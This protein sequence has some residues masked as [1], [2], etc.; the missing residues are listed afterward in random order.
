MNLHVDQ[1]ISHPVDL[2]FTTLR[3]RVTDLAPF[4]PNIAAIEYEEG[5][6]TEATKTSYAIRWHAAETEIPRAA[7]RFIDPSKLCWLD[8]AVWDAETRSCD[9]SM[10]VSMLPGRVRCGG[11]NSCMAAGDDATTFQI[12]GDLTIDV[13]GLV[14]RLIAGKVGPAVEG[15]VV[16]LIQPNLTHIGRAVGELLDSE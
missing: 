16:R 5:P 2:V 8:R 13:K 12:R 7:R 6:V 11:T 3:D 4:L 14:P 1:R 15:F 9:W 10:E